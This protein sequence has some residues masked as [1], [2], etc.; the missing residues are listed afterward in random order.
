M[1]I[2]SLGK[3]SYNTR[4][5]YMLERNVAEE[6]SYSRGQQM[7]FNGLYAVE[8]IPKFEML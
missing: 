2:D 6:G 7:P 5:C 8:V 4:M 1:S 3:L